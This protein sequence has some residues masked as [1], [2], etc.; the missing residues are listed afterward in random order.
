MASEDPVSQAL[1]AQEF[2]EKFG[3]GRIRC[4]SDSTL[5]VTDSVR[6]NSVAGST[7]C[8][9]VA[10]QAPREALGNL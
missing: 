8:R 1:Q 6:L 9:R 2:A 5:P 10:Q 7:G 3:S 4:P